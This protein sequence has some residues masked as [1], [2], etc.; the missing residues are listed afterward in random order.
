MDTCALKQ[1][2]PLFQLHGPVAASQQWGEGMI[3]RMQP[4]PVQVQKELHTF[5][6]HLCGPVANGPQTGNLDPCTK[7]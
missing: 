2:I 6:H 7:E 5:T 4:N 1:R 3:L